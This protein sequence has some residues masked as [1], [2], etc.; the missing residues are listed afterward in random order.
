MLC[1]DR[2][3]GYEG[4]QV[5]LVHHDILTELLGRHRQLNHDALHYSQFGESSE[6]SNHEI[7]LLC[8]QVQRFFIVLRLHRLS[9]KRLPIGNLL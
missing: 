6:Y 9:I 8:V 7:L 3:H 1:R 2:G 5:V 4:T